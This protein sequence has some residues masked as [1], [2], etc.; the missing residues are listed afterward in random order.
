MLKQLHPGMTPVNH[1]WE[2]V[3]QVL[4]APISRVV[5]VFYLLSWDSM[6]ST[7]VLDTESKKKK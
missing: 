7:E 1:L 3:Q 4:F 6:C 2:V 5:A